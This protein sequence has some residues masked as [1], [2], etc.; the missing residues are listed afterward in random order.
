MFVID[1]LA[2]ERNLG[3]DLSTVQ[4][5]FLNLRKPRLLLSVARACLQALEGSH[6][7]VRAA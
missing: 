4:A 1:S 6:P 3:C 2:F 5:Q 7:A